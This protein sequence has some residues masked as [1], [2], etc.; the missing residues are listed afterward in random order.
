MFYKHFSYIEILLYINLEGCQI[1]INV[2]FFVNKLGNS[3]NNENELIYKESSTT[4]L[5]IRRPLIVTSDVDVRE[6]LKRMEEG[7][8]SFFP[9]IEIFL[10]LFITNFR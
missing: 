9:L 5:R 3:L 6:S 8:E 10:Y 2:Y 7:K 4:H 1:Q